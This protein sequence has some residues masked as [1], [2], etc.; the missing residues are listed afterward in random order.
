M[1]NVIL[2]MKNIAVILSVLSTIICC[3]N[4]CFSTGTLTGLLNITWYFDMKSVYFG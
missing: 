1:Q 4:H 2:S 3:F